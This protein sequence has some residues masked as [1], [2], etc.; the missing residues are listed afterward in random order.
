MEISA[1]YRF[2]TF[3]EGESS[4][5]AF[6]A[7]N[8]VASENPSFSNPLVLVGGTGLGKTHLLH[9]IVNS[10]IAKRNGLKIVCTAALE[11][12][13]EYASA[14]LQKK[15]NPGQ[16]DE[17]SAKYR[18]ADVLVIDDLQNIEGKTASQHELLQIFNALLLACKPVV[19]ASQVPVS[20]IENLN[21]SLR[22][23]LTGGLTAQISL[24]TFVDRL[25]ILRKKFDMI[26]LNIEEN[27]LQFLAQKTSGTARDLEGIVSTLSFRV[28]QNNKNADIEMAAE[29]LEEHFVNSHRTVSMENI[30]KAV[31]VHY[32]MSV[33]ILKQ[34]SRGSKEAA[35]ARQVAMYLIRDMHKKSFEHIGKHFNKDGSTVVYACKSIDK[36]MQKEIPF[37]LEVNKIRKSL[38]D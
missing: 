31:A 12:Y 21:E 20:D 9:S 25:A 11:F 14:V 29:I 10:F 33:D 35:L 1:Q 24:P 16:M 19:V 15:E 27:V 7:A 26:Q 8:A 5:L 32:G 22:S 37:K 34:K 18:N 4:R 2:D 6:A 3:A 30:T 17:M 36:K 23:R 38:Y 13:E 28:R